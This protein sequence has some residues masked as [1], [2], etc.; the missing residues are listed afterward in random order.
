MGTTARTRAR[1]GPEQVLPARTSQVVGQVR[2][3]P[4]PVV[5]AV[6]VGPRGKRRIRVAE[7]GRKGHGVCTKTPPLSHTASSLGPSASR[8]VSSVTL[9]P[10]S[11]RPR[12]PK[13]LF[14]CLKVVYMQGK[15]WQ[16]A[17]SSS[18][19]LWPICPT[20]LG[21]GK[22]ADRSPLRRKPQ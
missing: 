16:D 3:C 4:H 17:Q 21:H 7:P 14:I 15:Q 22:F 18:V 11:A 1:L 13:S 8:G 2:E 5:V 10:G 9:S 12:S 6:D 19:S 20:G